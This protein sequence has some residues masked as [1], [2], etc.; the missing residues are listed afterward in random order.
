MVY[1]ITSAF[2]VLDIATGLINALKNKDYASNKMREGLFHKSALILCIVFGCLVDYAQGF[3]DL[4]ITVPM[5]MGICVYICL[6]EVGSIIENLTAINPE[7]M[8]D[9][10]KGFFRNIGE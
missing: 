8:P 7:I 2:M 6:M 5:T 10:L 1:I 9:K 4:G 3:M